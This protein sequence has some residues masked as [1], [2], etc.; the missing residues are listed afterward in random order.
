MRTSLHRV[1]RLLAFSVLVTVCAVP[2]GAQSAASQY[3]GRPIE[4]IRLFIENKPTTEAAVAELIEVKTG[5]ALSIAA[6]RESIAHIYSLGRFQDVQVEA[7]QAPGGGV[8]LRFNLIPFHSVQRIDF[9]GTL[10]L[11]SGLLRNAVVDRYGASPPIGRVDA[12]VRTLQQLYADNG[13]L[14]A[15]V[16]ASSEIQ[17]DPDRA[18]LTF[19]IDSGPRATI[20]RVVFERDP[21]V[22]REE[23]LRRLGAETGQ[24]F[25]RPRLQERLDDY[26][27]RLKARRF[28]EAGGTFNAVESEDGRTVDLV[29]SVRSGL[30]VSVR[31]DFNGSEPLSSDRLK[32]LAPLEREGSVD[33]DLLE[34]SEARIETYLRQ[35]GYW[36]AEVTVGREASDAA[37]TIV[38]N[39]IR[40]RQY[41]VAGPT[42]ITGTQ[43]VSAADV[44]ALV[45]LEP[46][47][48]FLESQL[49]A[50]V[51]AVQGFY[52]Q[53]G[54]A[55]VNVTSAVN[56]ADPVRPGEGLVRA[57]IVIVEG[58]RSAVGEI[59]I[60]G[61]SAVPADEL[62]PL[63]KISSGDPYYEPR[64]VE[65]RD[66]LVL[67]YLNRGFASIAVEVGLTSSVD[68]TRVDVT[69]T[70][71]EG[72]Q[73][74]VDHILIV[75]N[76]HT[77]P[78]VILRELQFK[79]G[80]PIGLQDQF[81]SRRRLSALGL[82]RR[83]QITE[84]SHGGGNEHDVLV[85]VE[86]APATTVGY[87]GGVEAYTKRRSTGPEGQAEDRLEFAP[88]GFFDI[89]RR[90]LFGANRSVS[91]YTRLSLR[92]R[93][94]PDDPEKDGTG[95]GFSEYRVVGTYRQPSWFG[96]NDL[97][98][99]GVLEQGVRT[100]FNFARQGVNVDVV[101]RLTPALRVS[102]RY[103][104]SSTRTFDERLTE[105]D[106]ARIDVLFPEVRLSGFSG[107][108]ARDTR[109]DLLEPTRGLFLSAE[110]S[111]AARALGGEVGFM[112]AY[113]QGFT[114]RRLPG[115]RTVVFASRAA[116]GLA[117]GFEREVLPT[118]AD[119]NP[120]PGLPIVIDDLP[121]SERFYAGGDT[122]IRGFALDGVGA[123]NTISANGYPTG[124]NAVLL[125]NGELRFPV[126]RDLG[127]VVF[128]DGGNVFRRVT[129]F[130]LGELRGSYGF[131]VR[132]HSPVGPIRVDLGFKMDSLRAGENRTAIHFSLGQA[133]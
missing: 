61:T 21:N 117:D 73:S 31:F 12:A 129:E 27:R 83:V 37:L 58:P 2:A 53:R 100:S 132:Y 92:P 35:Q 47:A 49:G 23:F 85:T 97:T 45:P 89:G 70:V 48:L 63:V 11:S 113:V 20:G 124:G 26:V 46:G 99:S 101:R 36:K 1:M 110:S 42:E 91:L 82:F 74:I 17:H 111:V 96:A 18:L 98:V 15:K 29:I 3:A 76:A 30:P 7:A 10:G 41:R 16:E 44:A 38:F 9:T 55:A 40:G 52:R 79:P 87:G 14:R 105:E 118:D 109:D 90:N 22:P 123:P 128:V 8:A 50:G 72:P 78:N 115:R 62:R 13:Y 24:A 130:D 69:F 126:W 6:V 51:G 77:K 95:I 33:E 88:R 106:Q 25:L 116:L 121:A 4:D 84:L 54:F 5:E 66:A 32:E 127:A 71:Q 108:V 39:V 119:G 102:G 75:G 60:A 28:F 94:A 104:L 120:I 64:A 86:E 59:R 56:E 122:T 133:F 34:D 68:R 67:E 103:S 65:A 125:L 80:Q 57:G 112:K 107:A 19:T 43:A 93:D 131:G 114:F 81:E